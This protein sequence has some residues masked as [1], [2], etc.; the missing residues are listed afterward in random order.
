MIDDEWNE[1]DWI[2]VKNIFPTCIETGDFYPTYLC[3]SREELERAWE[4]LPNPYM[5][6]YPHKSYQREELYG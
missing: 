1:E 4:E 5:K 3:K 2:L 6:Q